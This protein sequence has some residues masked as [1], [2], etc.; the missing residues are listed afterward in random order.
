MIKGRKADDRR[1]RRF[2]GVVQYQDRTSAPKQ[3][4]GFKPDTGAATGHLHAAGVGLEQ[5]AVHHLGDQLRPVQA[6]SVLGIGHPLGKD[7][8]SV[9]DEGAMGQLNRLQAARAEFAAD[10]AAEIDLHGSTTVGVAFRFGP[11]RPTISITIPSTGSKGSTMPPRSAL[12]Q[13]GRKRRIAGLSDIFGGADGLAGCYRVR[14]FVF[15]VETLTTVE[16]DA[17]RRR[18]S[19]TP[20]RRPL[21]RQGSDVEALAEQV[22]ALEKGQPFDQPADPIMNREPGCV[23]RGVAVAGA[24]AA[25]RPLESRGKAAVSPA[26]GARAA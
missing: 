22:N 13:R 12:I 11:Q 6:G 18:F 23:R 10:G 15:D 2:V 14:R 4:T 7:P 5:L 21:G 16:A 17:L 24:P 3:P 1:G 26:I 9:L 25:D 20:S 8:G 19:L